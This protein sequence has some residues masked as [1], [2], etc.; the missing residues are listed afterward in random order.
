MLYAPSNEVIAAL[1]HTPLTSDATLED[2]AKEVYTGFSSQLSDA[3]LLNSKAYSL[4]DGREAWLQEFSAKTSAGV[5]LHGFLVVTRRG[6]ALVGMW[7]MMDPSNVTHALPTTQT[8]FK[9]ISLTAPQLYGISRDQALFMAGGESNNPRE[10]DPATSG[11]NNIIYS[12]LVM[13]NPQLEVT[14]DLADSWETSADGKIYIFHLRKNARFHNGRPVTAQ[15]VVYSW[16]RAA[17]PATNSDLVLT[18]LGDIVGVADKRAGKAKTISGLKVINDNTLLVT[19]DAPKPYFLMKLT[20]GVSSVLDRANVE[21]GSNW[22]KT[23]NGTGPYKLIRWESGKAQLY[24]R[25]SDFYLTPPAI[26]YIV[27]QLYAGAGMRLYETGD[28]DVTGVPQFDVG[29]VLDPKE[30]LHADLL[31]GVSMCTSKVTFDVTKPPFNDPK[32][33]QAFALAVDRQR[34]VDVVQY[35]VGIPARG[36]YPPAL[37]GYNSKLIGLDFNPQLAKQRLAESSYGSA[38]KLPPIVFTSSGFGSDVDPGV[39]ALA[40]MWQKNLGVTIQVENLE[41]DK[42]QDEIH[43]GRHGQ[44][45]S[46]GWCADYPDPENFADAL[47]HSGAQQNVGHYSNPILDT[48]LEKARTER[49]V[50]LRMQMYAQ[51]EQAIVNDAAA[52]FLS[53]S[54]SYILV[55]PYIKGYTQTPINV[56]IFRYLSL[57][58]SKIK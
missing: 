15:D 1:F 36:L 44:L 56:P 3:Q 51:A 46:D 32:V 8:I 47:Y 9:S 5:A 4:Q 42:A 43:A 26:P 58:P 30:P 49:N 57:D 52:I 11:G 53:H 45:I 18:Y 7:V 12:G 40:D 20:Y 31:Q 33:R 21:S 13:L 39:A 10:Y 38:D 35:G 24:E 25:N 48:M 16:E 23:P 34:Y 2:T 28:I 54:L 29:R 37:P 6:S 14:P 17:D 27:V 55:K 22:Y 50:T 19:I 41:P